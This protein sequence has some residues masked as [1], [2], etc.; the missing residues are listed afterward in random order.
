VMNLCIVLT[1]S[2]AVRMPKTV[3]GRFLN[4]RPL[5]AVGLALPLVAVSESC[6]ESSR[7][8]VPNNLGLALLMSWITFVLMESLALRLREKMALAWKA[9]F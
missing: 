6:V 3:W 2:Q 1:I 4:L 5:R 8:R 9:A 7:L